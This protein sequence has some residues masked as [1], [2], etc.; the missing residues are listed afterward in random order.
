MQVLDRRLGGGLSG[1]PE[2]GALIDGGEKGRAVVARAAVAEAG[3]DGDERRQAVVFGTE[4]VTDPRAHAGAD[5]VGGA[6]VEKERGGSVR[7]TLGVHALQEAQVIDH[8]GHVREEFGRPVAALAALLE[9][10]K[11]LHHPHR[12]THAGLGER[13]GI[14]EVERNAVLLHH[15][16]LV[17]EGIDV[18]DTACHEQK[19]DALG[20]REMV[21]VQLRERVGDLRLLRSERRERKRA[22]SAGGSLEELA[23]G[24]HGGVRFWTG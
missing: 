5:E 11:R 6:G 3:A 2:G 9:F 16:R 23:S 14:V 7:D 18:A 21:R 12:G 4:T 15:L 22:E 10:P 24:V 20:L 19:D 1:A 17:V 13:A 8:S